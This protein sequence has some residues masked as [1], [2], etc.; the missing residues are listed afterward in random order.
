MVNE[1]GEAVND[2]IAFKVIP[3][4]GYPFN[5][6]ASKGVVEYPV[7]DGDY[8]TNLMT[9]QLKN[10]SVQLDGKEYIVVPEKHEFTIQSST[11]GTLVT[12][13]DGEDVGNGKE[14]IFI[15]T[16][17]TVPVVDKS[18]L[19]AKVNEVKDMK[20]GD[21]TLNSY[22]AFKTAITEAETALD[23]PNATQQ[24]VDQA[25]SALEEAQNN[26]KTV[27]GMR[28]LTIAVSSEDGSQLQSN[29][30]FIRDNVYYNVQNTMFANDGTL[31]WKLTGY[32]DAGEYEIYLPED[33]V[34]I[35]TPAV[36]KITIGKEDGTSVV[37][38][39]NGV[40]A[41]EAQ[42]GI[43][44]LAKSTDACDKVT[45][46]AYV[47]DEDGKI[48]PGISFN[49]LNG[50]P[51]VL[52]SDENGMI[53]YDV[54]VWDIDTD[55]TVSLQANDQWSCDK[56]VIF[57]VSEDPE[58]EG[59]GVIRAIDGTAFAGGEKIVFVLRDKN[60]PQPVDKTG[61]EGAIKEAQAIEKDLYTEESYGVMEQALANALTVDRDDNATQENIDSA[62][63]ALRDAMNG[64]VK[65]EVP[66]PVNKEALGKAIKEA[67]A[68]KKDDYTDASFTAFE[69]ALKNAVA[70]NENAVATQEEVNNAEKTL[71]DAIAGLVKKDG[72][73]PTPNPEDKNQNKPNSNQQK[74][75]DTNQTSNNT[76][77]T[78]AAQNTTVKT[79][80]TA[81]FMISIAGI[82]MAA[83]LLVLAI[84]LRKKYR[85]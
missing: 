84:V 74:L 43:R 20:Q 80:D 70:I 11:L 13:V 58:V 24:D 27:R 26:L 41:A 37:E 31:V 2:S 29:I 9:V 28:T 57:T 44:L 63:Q 23:N 65:K 78:N 39:I 19:Q 45:F 30:K 51:Q 50:D 66:Q 4:T 47:Q 59:R 1:A 5:L 79:G 21:Y 56:Q 53:Q 81:N 36:T 52:T 15:L 16:E 17:K 22:K 8:G 32:E 34:Y 18:M 61:L 72:E 54:T 7:S 42:A 62:A 71:R 82:G 77:P 12:K 25:L 49:V 33:S 75:S 38:K 35:A 55:M 73:T 64:L 85:R 48:L 6:Y 3:D 76:Q 67:Q 10:E 68:L 40:P 69:N 60:K 46:R 83:I 14:V